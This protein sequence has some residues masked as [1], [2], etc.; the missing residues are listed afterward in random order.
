[1]TKPATGIAAAITDDDA[2][3]RDFLLPLALRPKASLYRILTSGFLWMVAIPLL[4]AAVYLFAFAAPQYRSEAQIMIRGIDTPSP[5]IGGF[6]QLLGAGG[7]LNNSQ[8]EAYSLIKYLQSPDALAALTKAGINPAEIFRR[9]EA[10]LL[11]R[12]WDAKPQAEDL[13]AHYRGQVKMNLDQDTGITEISVTTYR[14]ADSSAMAKKILALGE[15]RVNQLNARLIAATVTLAQTE[16]NE[17][18]GE[19][20]SVQSALANFRNQSNDI[21]PQSSGSGGQ[22][23]VFAQQEEL[24]RQQAVLSDM[25]RY[26]SPDSPQVIAMQSKIAALRANSRQTR[27]RLTGS[28]QSVSQKLGNYEDLKLQQELAAKR[29]ELARIGLKDAS[30]RA[31]KDRLFVVQIVQPGLPEKP[32]FPKPFRSLLTIFL[33]LMLAYALMRLIVSGIREH[34]A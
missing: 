5:S 13:L 34:R 19:L 26:L 6:G 17:A 7:V 33:G 21:D 31:E 27:G 11:T 24:D 28:A 8:R 4:I 2:G 14:P 30:E 12:L 25:L 20:A 3:P 32:V 16:M 18:Q 15:E 22:K 9:P 23:Q 10:D 29:F 1:M